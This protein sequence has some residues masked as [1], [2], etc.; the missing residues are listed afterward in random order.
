[1]L[2][3]FLAGAKAITG[4]TL[5]LPA[6]LLGSCSFIEPRKRIETGTLWSY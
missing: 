6:G 5:D 1:M 3:T 4:N 2:N